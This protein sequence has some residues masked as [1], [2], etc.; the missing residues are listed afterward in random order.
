MTWELWYFDYWLMHLIYFAAGLIII[1]ALASN[2]YNDWKYKMMI[3]DRLKRQ[4]ELGDI[5]PQYKVAK[6]FEK[7]HS[8]Q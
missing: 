1:F 8:N 3:L 5:D 4:T 6:E 7:W 2:Y